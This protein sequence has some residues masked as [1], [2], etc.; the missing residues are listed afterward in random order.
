MA[1]DAS[2]LH[3]SRFVNIFVWSQIIFEGSSYLN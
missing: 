2:D 3:V 1:G